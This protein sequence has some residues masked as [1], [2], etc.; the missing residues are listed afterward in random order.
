MSGE[1]VAI[2]SDRLRVTVDPAVGGAITAIEHLGLGRSVL[3][4]VPWTP[5]RSPAP[6]YAAPDEQSWLPHYTG[7]WPI[8]FPNGGDACEFEGVFHGFHGEASLAPWEVTKAGATLRLSRRFAAVPVEMDRELVVE[9]DVLSIRERLVMRGVRPVKAM[10]GHHATFGSD[11]L[12]GPFEVQAAPCR[13]LIDDR[14]DPPANPLR[15][16]AEGRWPRL[17]GKDGAYDLSRPEGK[18]AAQV[19]LLDFAQPWL[20]IRRLDVSLAVALS[21]DATVFPCAWLWYEL[22]ATDD[23]PWFGKGRLIGLEPNSSWPGNGL[24]DVARRRAR[25]VTLQPGGEL[26]SWVRLHVFKPK[27]A[28]LGV[29]ENG[30]ALPRS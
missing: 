22:G 21:W 25:L 24:A 5:V 17:P 28:I 10:W 1:P 7:G 12:A 3:G 16:G 26:R 30:R 8:L 20:A 9:G 18:V 13:A 14:Y 15:P 2:E 6:P 11:L 29:D 23:P 4:K 19:Y 27:G